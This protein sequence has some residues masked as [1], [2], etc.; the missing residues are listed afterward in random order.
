MVKL[1]RTFSRFYR[2][3]FRGLVERG[4]LKKVEYKIQR[5][6]E[7]G[8]NLKESINIQTEMSYSVC[9]SSTLT[10]LVKKCY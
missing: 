10:H 8:G 4:S 7:P 5:K 6:R 2:L 9:L 1:Y 3:P